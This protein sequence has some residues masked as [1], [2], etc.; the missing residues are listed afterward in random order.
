MMILESTFL[1][2]VGNITSNNYS[3]GFKMTIFLIIF[4]FLMFILWSYIML[5]SFNEDDRTKY[6]M[7]FVFLS[8]SIIGFV[9]K[10]TDCINSVE[11]ENLKTLFQF[12]SKFS[13][14]YFLISIIGIIFTYFT[15]NHEIS[16]EI[17][18]R[19]NNFRNKKQEGEKE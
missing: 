18:K 13:F 14:L 12:L 10:I 6:S 8:W 4:N 16:K 3:G 2:S 15:S 1:I 17:I 7:N 5:F 11:N 19:F 9:I